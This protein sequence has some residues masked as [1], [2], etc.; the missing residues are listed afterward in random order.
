LISGFDRSTKNRGVF[1]VYSAKN[2][3]APFMV[4]D[5]GT[6]NVPVEIC[7]LFKFKPGIK[8]TEIRGAFQ[9]RIP[10][11]DSEQAGDPDSD[12]AADFA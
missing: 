2:L 8:A 9:D 3:F 10:V 11:Y 6:E 5:G 12:S 1:I 7:T 4:K